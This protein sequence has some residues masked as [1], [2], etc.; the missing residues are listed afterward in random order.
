[1]D[2]RWCKSHKRFYLK[3]CYKCVQEQDFLDDYH[4]E[5]MWQRINSR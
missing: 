4:S 1:M 5:M 2:I 3:E